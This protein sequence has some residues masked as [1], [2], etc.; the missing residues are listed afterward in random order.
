MQSFSVKL[1]ELLA[2]K[3]ISGYVLSKG[4]GLPPSTISRI[5][6]GEALRPRSRT[7]A[8][9][10]AF[11]GMSTLELTNDTELQT[12]Y[13]Q[14]KGK[15][16]KGSRVPF[17]D[18]PSEAMHLSVYDDV[19]PNVNF[20]P[21]FPLPLENDGDLIAIKMD[22]DALAPRI[23]EGDILYI[24]ARSRDPKMNYSASNGQLVLALPKET[25]DTGKA[26]VREYKKD[27]I[28]EEW[29]VA[30]NPDWPGKRAL[31][32]GLIVGVVVGLAAKL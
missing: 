32:V 1:K 25:S 22:S 19:P 21:P 20:L 29:L 5:L 3:G 28:D 26:I 27:D 16:F 14:Q 18:S 10:A 17:L 24:D 8:D 23:R 13:Q 31:H 12:C 9:I 7:L 15:I 11:L 4:T 2:E 6:N 30:T